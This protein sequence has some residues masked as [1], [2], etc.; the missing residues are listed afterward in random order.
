MRTKRTYTA[1]HTHKVVSK[2]K[3]DLY[4]LFTG[5]KQFHTT[6]Q[7]ANSY[8]ANTNHLLLLMLNFIYVTKLLI[9]EGWEKKDLEIREPLDSAAEHIHNAVVL[10]PHLIIRGK[11]KG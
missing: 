9:T 11:R 8:T 3:M 10:L 2:F 1:S 4:T 5:A 6:L 7:I